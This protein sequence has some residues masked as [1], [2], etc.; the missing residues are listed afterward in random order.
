MSKKRYVKGSLL[1]ELKTN[2][3]IMFGSFDV[4]GDVATCLDK[5]KRFIQ[6]PR[7]ILDTEYATAAELEKRAREKRKG[8]AW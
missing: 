8:Q 4:S 1:I 6:I 3:K 2:Q 7:H 5:N